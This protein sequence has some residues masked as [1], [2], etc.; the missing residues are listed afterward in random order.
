VRRKGHLRELGDLS[1]EEILGLIQDALRDTISHSALWFRAA[2]DELGMDEAIGLDDAAWADSFP[3][4]SKRLCQQLGWEETG[5]MPDFLMGL[6]KDGL[7]GVLEDLAKNWLTNDG[8]WFRSVETAHGMALAKKLNDEAWKRFTVIEAK[9][10]MK[11]LKIA[12]NGGLVAL[13]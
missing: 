8:V 10:I 1:K 2:E 3:L 4:Q 7:I 6:G 9:R 5:S 11:R 12:E 13:E